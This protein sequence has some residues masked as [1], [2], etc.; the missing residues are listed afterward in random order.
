MMN[1][2]AHIVMIKNATKNFLTEI[3]TDVI[4]VLDNGWK[5]RGRMKSAEQ[6]LEDILD[7]CIAKR[8]DF[9]ERNCSRKFACEKRSCYPIRDF[10]HIINIIKERTNERNRKDV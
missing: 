7:F 3:I 5:V 1:M 9:C 2:F 6:K 4:K 8:N 10:T